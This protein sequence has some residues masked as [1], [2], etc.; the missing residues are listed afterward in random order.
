MAGDD[1]AGRGQKLFLFFFHCIKTLAVLGDL[2]PISLDVLQ[3]LGE[4]RVRALVDLPVDGGG[5]LRLDINIGSVSFGRGGEDVVGGALD[6]FHELLD[7]VG[8]FGHEGII[9]CR[10]QLSDQDLLRITAN[11]P[12]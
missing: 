1:R 4:V 2:L 7:L 6:G 10:K 9:C 11:I 8:V 3:I 12:M 5:H